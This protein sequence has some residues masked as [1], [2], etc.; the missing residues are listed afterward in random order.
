[1]KKLRPAVVLNH[2]RHHTLQVLSPKADR[3]VVTARAYTQL[4]TRHGVPPEKAKQL[5]GIPQ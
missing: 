5:L 1:V 4:V 2:P 3:A